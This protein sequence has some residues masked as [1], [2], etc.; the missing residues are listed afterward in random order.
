MILHRVTSELMVSVR[1]HIGCMHKL[2][3]GVS[4]IDMMVSFAHSC[5]ISNYGETLLFIFFYD[6]KMQ[7]FG[8]VPFRAIKLSS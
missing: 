8:G 7:H 6:L 5:T 2:A 1:E 4:I 3:E